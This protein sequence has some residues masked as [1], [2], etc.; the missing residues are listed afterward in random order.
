M[1]PL[2]HEKT[3]AYVLSSIYLGNV[4]SPD[5]LNAVLRDI[6]R[7]GNRQIVSQ[8]AKLATLVGQ[9][10][11]QLRVLTILSCEDLLKLEDWCIDRNSAVALE[12][13]FDCGSKALAS[14]AFL[15][16]VEKGAE[17]RQLPR[18]CGEDTDLFRKFARAR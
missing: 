6:T 11:D 15:A 8:R 9:V 17:R 10:V 2:A 1:L 18:S 12:D 7:K 4:I 13:F 16:V 14:E 5:R 3:S